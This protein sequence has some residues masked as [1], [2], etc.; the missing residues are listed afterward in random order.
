MQLGF[1]NPARDVVRRCPFEDGLCL[2]SS[3]FG[4]DE[5]FIFSHSLLDIRAVFKQMG[6]YRQLTCVSLQR[7]QR[8]R[9]LRFT[10]IHIE[11]LL[12]TPI[13]SVE[14]KSFLDAATASDAWRIIGDGKWRSQSICLHRLCLLWAKSKHRRPVKN[15]E[16][17]K[18]ERLQWF[19]AS[20]VQSVDW[21]MNGFSHRLWSS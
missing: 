13:F 2:F 12:N 6:L 11:F 17:E 18:K 21:V 16:S 8:S 20:W 4:R 3:S 10:R 1:V 15:R 5:I 9:V 14:T 19:L 7:W